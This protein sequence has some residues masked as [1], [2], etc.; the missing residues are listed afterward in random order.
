MLKVFLDSITKPEELQA[1]C[2]YKFAPKSA[3]AASLQ[4]TLAQDT[5][6]KS[7]Y[8][9]LNLVKNIL[10]MSFR[11]LF[12]FPPFFYTKTSRSFAAVIQELDE[13]LRDSVNS[14]FPLLFL[15]FYLLKTF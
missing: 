10:C 8:E 5:S 1:L 9:F 13:E 15:L 7:C 3:S 12:T 2:K 6:K 4:R 11:P 14:L